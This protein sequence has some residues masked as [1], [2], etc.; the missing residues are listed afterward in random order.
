MSMQSLYE[1]PTSLKKLATNVAHAKHLLRCVVCS[2]IPLRCCEF[3]D[4]QVF[5]V[6]GRLSSAPSASRNAAIYTQANDV[7]I[8]FYGEWAIAAS[9]VDPGDVVILEGFELYDVP[10]KLLQSSPKT[11][12]DQVLVRP[13][14]TSS[15]LRVL[16]KGLGGDIMEV[17]VGPD[18]SHLPLIRG[19]PRLDHG[20][21]E[22]VS[23]VVL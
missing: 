14:P 19:L 23:Q 4:S 8:N 11:P 18:S 5:T 17:T 13:L 9:F 2:A 12:K 6:V 7:R 16:Q 22:Y 15:K 10:S 3:N 21:Y 1:T 20:N